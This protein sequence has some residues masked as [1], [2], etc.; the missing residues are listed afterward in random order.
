MN[1]IQRPDQM[2]NRAVFGGMLILLGIALV[3][4]NLNILPWRLDNI[5]F[6]W[7]MLLIALGAIL[8]VGKKEKTIGFILIAI[9]GGFLIPEIFQLSYRMERFFWPVI[10]IIVGIVILRKRHDYSNLN[11]IQ[12]DQHSN[13]LN[14]MNILGGGERIIT[15]QNFKGGKVTCVFGGCEINLANAKLSEGTNYLDI[16]TMFGGCVL[17][18]PSDWDVKVEITSILGGFGDKRINPVTYLVEPRKE[19]VIRGTALLGG[20]EIKS[21]K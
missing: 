1:N 13:Y 17:I 4:K 8:Y 7:Q 5:I 16:F 3:L 21:Y 6:S 15:S 18:V 19:L 14:E 2:D 9:G 11:K 12:G 10:L 20:G